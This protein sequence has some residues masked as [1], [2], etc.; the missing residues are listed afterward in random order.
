MN[1]YS[2]VRYEFNLTPAEI[3]AVK[4]ILLL[5][6]GKHWRL[7]IA[8]L[9]MRNSGVS[10]RAWFLEK[11]EAEAISDFVHFV[12]NHQQE[13]ITWFE[14]F[15]GQPDLD[16][17]AAIMLKILELKFGTKWGTASASFISAFLPPDKVREMEGYVQRTYL[18]E[19]YDLARDFPDMFLNW[20]AN[21]PP[22]L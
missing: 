21:T 1:A 18:L 5:A 12:F 6:I 16:K 7:D 9:V 4:S 22:E 15:K 3:E 2:R 17:V 10:E 14:L 20:I 13:F 19:F 11:N 8:A